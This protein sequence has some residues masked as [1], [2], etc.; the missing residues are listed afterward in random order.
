MSARMFE[1]FLK[2][3]ISLK[4]GKTN[5]YFTWTYIYFW[6][7]LNQFIS[8]WEMFKKKSCREKKKNILYV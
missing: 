8:E 5:G 2:I 6:S 1:Y 3:Q 7:Y 4:S